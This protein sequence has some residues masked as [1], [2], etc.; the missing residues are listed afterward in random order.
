MS[1]LI[2]QA[3]LATHNECWRGFV[4]DWSEHEQGVIVI[5]ISPSQRFVAG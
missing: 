5:F 2:S 1:Y 3:T 4:Q